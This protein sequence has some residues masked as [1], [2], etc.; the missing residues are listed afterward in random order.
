M[1]DESKIDVSLVRYFGVEILDLIGEP[2]SNEFIHHMLPI[3]M[4]T[5]IF[6]NNTLSKHPQIGQF[7]DS[8]VGRS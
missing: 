4:K 2:F 3:V 8:V 6:D 7:I 1:F 5:E